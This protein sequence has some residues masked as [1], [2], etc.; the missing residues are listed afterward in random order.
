M[1]VRANRIEE[2]AKSGHTR[3]CDR[4]ND[5]GHEIKY[6]RLGHYDATINSG[7]ERHSRHFVATEFA[8]GIIIWHGYKA[9]SD[10]RHGF[11]TM[12]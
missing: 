12:R 8:F 5:E 10:Q 1:T 2:G 7:S 4:R 9:E 6:E 11:L 3:W